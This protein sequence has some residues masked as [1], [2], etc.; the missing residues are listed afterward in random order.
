MKITLWNILQRYLKLSIIIIIFSDH[1][2]Q[3]ANTVTILKRRPAVL[4]NFK[5]TSILVLTMPPTEDVANGFNQ[6]QNG[7]NEFP[8]MQREPP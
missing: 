5:K 4:D 8:S 1:L 3:R 7:D 2:V 6:A